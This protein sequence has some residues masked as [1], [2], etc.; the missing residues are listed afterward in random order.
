MNE[1]EQDFEEDKEAVP[2]E[3]GGTEK[4]YKKKKAMASAVGERV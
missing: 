4:P 1:A 2:E 3:T